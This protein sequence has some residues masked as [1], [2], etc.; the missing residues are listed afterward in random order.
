MIRRGAVSSHSRIAQHFLEGSTYE[1][2]NFVNL[3]G[4]LANVR[5]FGRSAT[6]GRFDVAMLNCY[7]VEPRFIIDLGHVYNFAYAF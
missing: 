6:G 5:F 7:P 1:A 3:C 4:G 2:H